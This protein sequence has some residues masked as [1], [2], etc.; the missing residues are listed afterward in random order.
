MK[1]GILT[2]AKHDGRSPGTT[3][4][5]R[6]RGDWIL[7]Y[8]PDA[9]E[10]VTGKQYDAV[11]YQKAYFLDHARRF[12][13]FK[14]LDLCDPDWMHWGYRVK[15]MITHCDV[16]TTSTEQLAEAIRQFADGKPVICVPDRMDLEFYREKKIH[17]GEAKNVSWFGYSTNFD[18]LNSTVPTLAKL[19][20][21]L[22]VISNNPYFIPSFYD[23]D[24]ELIN[25][26]W[27]LETSNS[28][29]IKGDILLNPKSVKGKFKYKSNNKTLSGWAL[30]MPVA[31]NADELKKFMSEE[32]RKKEAE[33]KLAEVKNN[34]DV[35]QS[36][37]QYKEII[38][39]YANKQ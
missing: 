3:G 1:I 15:E 6:I 27:K 25:Y 18:L 7:K 38:E 9:E 33:E 26:P 32:A 34:W 23:N 36:V 12:E 4:S 22:I 24:I 39:K 2:F 20:L 28:D 35:K 10:F 16:V 19:G 30:G 31:H 14:I 8:W 11:I 5:T 37:E 29:I 17:V 13:G 21:G